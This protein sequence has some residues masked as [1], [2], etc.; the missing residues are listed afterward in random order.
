M[1]RRAR[2]ISTSRSATGRLVAC[3]VLLAFLLQGIALQTHIHQQIQPVIAKLAT[4]DNQAGLPSVKVLDQ[5]PLKTQ[6]PLDQGHC[7]LCHELVHAGSYI[8]PSA[9]ALVAGLDWIT[10]HSPAPAPVSGTPA[11][12][13]A[14]QSRG[15]PQH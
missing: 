12:G 14:W 11:Q 8:T 9:M 13:F 6:D 2:A 10:A 4:P 3:F 1:M 5:Q 7:R 15:P